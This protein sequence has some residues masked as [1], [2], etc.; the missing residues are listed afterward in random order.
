MIK[1]VQIN[2]ERVYCTG[3]LHG[4][5]NSIGYQIKRF[6]IHNA[7]I[8]CCGDIG[9]GFNK[10]GYY[11]QTFDK[12]KKTLTKYNDYII[13]LRGNHDDK[14][15]FDGKTI[16]DKRIKAVEDYTVVQ[17]FFTDDKEHNTLP[18][19]ILCVGGATSIDRSYR[20][21]VNN[22]LLIEYAHN[23]NDTLE[24]AKKNAPKCYWENEVP[25]YDEN[26]LNEIKE[27]G[28]TIDAVATHTCPT[29]C[30]PTTKNGIVYWMKLDENLEKDI[31]NERNVMD[32]LY[33]KLQEDKHPL[34]IW[35]YGHYHFHNNE[36]INS[37]KFFLIDME[38]DGKMD[39]VEIYSNV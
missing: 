14:A 13:F 12:L 39:M 23:H 21:T 33:N 8:I 37:T 4:N 16:N 31:D 25:I 15:Y 17:V 7:L 36:T 27:N 20:M 6:D 26:K 30:Q 32:L 9:L 22:K 35:C 24:D 10:L 5:F 29:F 34:T 1:K 19:N 38:R 2:A 11:K 3:D 18:F 28:I